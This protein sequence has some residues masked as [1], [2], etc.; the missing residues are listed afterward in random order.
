MKIDLGMKV[1][2]FFIY[3][4]ILQVSCMLHSCLFVYSRQVQKLP[5]AFSWDLTMTILQM[6]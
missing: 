5:K 3:F 1:D 4:V 2:I 6:I